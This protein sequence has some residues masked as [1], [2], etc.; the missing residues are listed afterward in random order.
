[1]VHLPDPHTEFVFTLGIESYALVAALILIVGV[2][3]W[4]WLR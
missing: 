2:A 1:M 3:Q 4:I